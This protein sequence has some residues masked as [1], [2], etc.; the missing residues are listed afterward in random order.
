MPAR[1][2]KWRAVYGEIRLQGVQRQ[3]DSLFLYE[4]C[5]GRTYV[6]PSEKQYPTGHVHVNAQMRT[7]RHGNMTMTAGLH[8]LGPLDGLQSRLQGLLPAMIGRPCRPRRALSGA[9]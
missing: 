3:L 8:A 5:L 7:S 9:S 4:I 2:R 1:R 6:I